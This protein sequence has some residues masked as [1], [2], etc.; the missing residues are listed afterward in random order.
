[1]YEHLSNGHTHVK[2]QTSHLRLIALR[3][4]EI[5]CVCVCVTMNQCKKGNTYLNTDNNNYLAAHKLTLHTHTHHKS[6]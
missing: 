6:L 5:K 1:M 4:K 3:V 2:A